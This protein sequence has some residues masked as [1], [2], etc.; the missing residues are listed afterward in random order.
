[1]EALQIA[2]GAVEIALEA[3]FV[4]AEAVQGLL[5]GEVG[6]GDA[7]VLARVPDI[8][9]L[10]FVIAVL[11]MELFMGGFGFFALQQVGFDGAEAAEAKVGEGH[12]FDE[13]LFDGGLGI[14]VAA[15]VL[16]DGGEEA[17]GL[18]V[19]ETGG[20]ESVDEVIAAGASLAFGR[21]RA[22]GAKGVAAVGADLGFG[23]HKA[24]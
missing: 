12:A 23:G 8:P 19:Q 5:V 3:G 15:E 2:E 4:E 21:A 16:M 13:H 20:G 9:K 14:E 18:V 10:V 11:L 24:I 1:L 6:L 22:G 7:A 17:G